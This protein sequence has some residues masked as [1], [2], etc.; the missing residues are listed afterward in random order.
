MDAT[1]DP[2]KDAR[3]DEPMTTAE[4]IGW[5][6]F[7]VG[8]SSHSPLVLGQ[9]SR[10][11][12]RSV[13]RTHGIRHARLNRRH[14]NSCGEMASRRQ[15]AVGAN[16]GRRFESEKRM[17]DWKY[18][19]ARR[20]NASAGCLFRCHYSPYG[21]GEDPRRNARTFMRRKC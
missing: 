20:P 7:G 12:H 17:I 3:H 13:R 4:L 16:C 1:S 6:E 14:G 10:G 5:I 9:R 2:E 8:S 19:A 15:A 11:L 18:F 21:Y